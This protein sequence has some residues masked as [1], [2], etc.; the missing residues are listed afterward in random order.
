MIASQKSDS[1]TGNRSAKAHFRFGENWES[2]ART[3]DQAQ[4]AEAVRSLTNLVPPEAIAGKSFL[5]I[6]CG[7]G[8][9]ML[10]ALRL[11]AE[12]VHG[13]DIDA[14]SVATARALLSRY[15]PSSKWTVDERTVFDLDAAREQFEIVYSWG[16]LHHTGAMW[17][18]VECAASMVAENGLLV[19]ALYHRTPFCRVWRIEKRLY[20]FSLKPIQQA[21][22]GIYK[23]AFVAAQIARARNPVRYIAG[24]RRH[25]GMNWHHDVHDWLGGYPYESTGKAE[26]EQRLRPLGFALALTHETHPP[27]M[28]LFGTGCDEYVASRLSSGG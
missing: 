17:Q 10:A 20:A 15:A 9:S 18:A 8:L 22:R 21:L 5:D 2:F 6:G 11:G 13:I 4:I 19:M 28:G 24:Y 16:V 1:D 26:V 25:R 14:T 7:S 23:A 12:R 27:V 3:V